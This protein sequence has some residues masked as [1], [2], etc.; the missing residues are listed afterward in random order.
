[1]IGI[2]TYSWHKLFKL[3]KEGWID[4]IDEILEK[5][6]IFITHEVK[7]E[8]E[9]WF[10]GEKNIFKW[11]TILP[12][13]NVQFSHFILKGFDPADA[14]L[15]EYA[16]LEGYQIITEDHPMLMEG[17]TLR[18]NIIQLADFFGILTKLG[19]ITKK[20]LYQLVKM[21]RKMK[22]ITKKKESEL[23][24]PQFF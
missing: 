10:P 16:L 7:K 1:M 20:E 13:R 8:L 22:N 15:L 14:S 17:V 3:R 6:A 11:F 19:F 23:L 5:S 18:Q 2:D 4:L 21:L 9:Y 12:I 24:N